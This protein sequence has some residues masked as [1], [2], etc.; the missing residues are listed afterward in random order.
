MFK[1]VLWTIIIAIIFT[2]LSGIFYSIKVIDFN[3][4]TL[5]CA[6]GIVCGIMWMLGYFI[7]AVFYF[8]D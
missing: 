8:C 3:W 6:C 4:H 7:A 5:G 2:I 1:V